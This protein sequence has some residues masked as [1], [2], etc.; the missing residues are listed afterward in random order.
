M[1][2]RALIL[3]FSVFFIMF[4]W[5]PSAYSATYNVTDNNG[6][7]VVS[8]LHAAII[9]ANA[10]AGTDTITFSASVNS[11]VLTADLP[12]ITETLTITG[13]GQT[14]LTISGN[15]SYSMFDNQTNGVTFTASDLTLTNS[16]YV[17]S[18]GG[19]LM[20]SNNAHFVANNITVSG[21]TNSYAFYGKNAN[22]ITISN[23]T[24]QNNSAMLFG[25]DHAALQVQLPEVTRIK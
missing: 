16:K 18:G 23:S 1:N 19:I 25:S 8:S 24:F 15:G 12:A 13:P 22:T 17:S 11:I 6:G 2:I 9:L 4:N 10:N 7:N 21:V 20:N 3:S 14:N 5:A